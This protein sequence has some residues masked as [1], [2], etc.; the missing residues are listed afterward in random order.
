MRKILFSLVILAIATL[1]CGRTVQP[2]VVNPDPASPLIAMS[3]IV[4]ATSPHPTI[5][6]ARV[7]VAT[8]DLNV[9]L[10]PGPDAIAIAWLRTGESATDLYTVG[11]W[12]ALRLA[13]GLDGY[14]HGNWLHCEVKK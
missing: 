4:P 12:H 14:A 5:Q 3:T 11:V 1:A 7:C 9:R 13:N 10:Q 6:P 2:A 8:G